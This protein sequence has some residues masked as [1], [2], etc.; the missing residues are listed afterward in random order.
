[1]N[2][3]KAKEINTENKAKELANE[4]VKR[5]LKER[6][7]KDE[8]KALAKEVAKEAI[9][10]IVNKNKDRRYQNT[11]LLMENYNN[12]KAHIEGDEDNIDI[13]LEFRDET[14]EIYIKTDYMWLESISKSKART[15]EMLRYVDEKLEFLKYK[16]E[17]LGK[18]EIVSSFIMF[19][20]DGNTDEEIR[21]KHPCGENTPR[22]WRNKILRELSV[23]LWGIDAI[24][25]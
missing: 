11:K 4:I 16:Y 1:M 3:Y 24:K 20:I 10:D 23:L 9:F 12:L 8:I 5:A 2:P 21:K 25:M 7:D 19:Y 14:G 18:E 6:T 15:K 22:R 17:K 13:K